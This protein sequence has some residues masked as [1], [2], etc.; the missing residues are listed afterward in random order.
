MLKMKKK[1]MKENRIRFFI[2]LFSTHSVLTHK[3]KCYYY[4][5]CA[6]FFYEATTTNI[7]ITSI[8]DVLRGE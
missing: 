2:L 8:I 1:N 6:Q 4:F 5:F 7:M 3:L